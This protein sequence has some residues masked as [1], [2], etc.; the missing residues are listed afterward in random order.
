M[1]DRALEGQPAL[2]AEKLL[3]GDLQIRRRAPGPA[4][5]KSD[6]VAIY[7]SADVTAGKLTEHK[8][9][10]DCE[11]YLARWLAE[12]PDGAPA[13]EGYGFASP[14]PAGGSGKRAASS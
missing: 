3:N 1:V 4:Y 10:E 14:G 5:K 11:S 8:I 7:K 9:R 2:V 6:V 12:H 13:G